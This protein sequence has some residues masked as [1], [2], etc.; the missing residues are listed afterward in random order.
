MG[1][2]SSHV[3]GHM[4]VVYL[5]SLDEVTSIKQS[6]CMQPDELMAV[7]LI[8]PNVMMSLPAIY[9]YIPVLIQ[10]L[11]QKGSYFQRKMNC[12]VHSACSRGRH[13]TN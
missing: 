12:Q 5:P 9:M 3:T 1:S 11:E 2:V 4:T 6:G 10:T 8:Y 13:S 7:S